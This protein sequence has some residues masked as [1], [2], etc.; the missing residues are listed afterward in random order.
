MMEILRRITEL[1]RSER[2][3]PVQVRERAPAR[4]A[5]SER[6]LRFEDAFTAA[7]LGEAFRKVRA[8]GGGAGP[9]AQSVEAFGQRLD[10]NLRVLE[11][12]L[13]SGRYRPQPVLRVW[14]PKSGGEPGERRPISLLNVRDRVAQRA[15]HTALAPYYESRFHECSFGFRESRGVREAVA[16]VVR[17]RDEGL[18]HVVDGDIRRCFESMEHDV[19]M[20]LLERDIGDAR[21]TAIIERWLRMGVLSGRGK[22]GAAEPQERGVGQGAAISPLLSNIY[23]HEFDDAMKQKQRAL[24][25]YA[26]DWVILCRSRD[27]AERALSEARTALEHIR[28]TLNPH[29]TRITD[30]ANGWSF[31]GAFFVRDEQYWVKG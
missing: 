8:N 22:N 21:Y 14:L 30:F 2:R 12:E 15:A 11:R 13:R 3:P 19:L 7:A 29:K 26:D 23:L 28:L 24:V 6:P 4:R 16:E 9:D 1:G 20:R 10:D 5:V 31:L 17:L 27:D 25:R 18:H